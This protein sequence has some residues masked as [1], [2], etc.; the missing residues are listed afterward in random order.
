MKCPNCSF[1][2]SDD[3]IS[4]RVC[5]YELISKPQTPKKRVVDDSEDEAL[6]SALKVLFGVEG[7]GKIMDEEDALDAAMM[8]RLLKKKRQYS[9]QELADIE[10]PESEVDDVELDKAIVNKTR[11]VR[12]FTLVLVIL[13]IVSLLFKTS[14]SSAPWKYSANNATTTPQTTEAIA[15][16]TETSTYE[17]FSLGGEESLE[18]VNAFFIML[19]EFIN[20]GNLNILTLF[21]NS[22]E[23]LDLLTQFASIG[24]L[25]KVADA[26]IEQSE[27]DES[28]AS[29]TVSTLLNRLINGQQTQTPVTW[30]FR[31]VNSS[32]RWTIESFSI[33]TDPQMTTESASQTQSTT[34]A[35]T[36]QR[37]T[38]STTEATTEAPKAELTGFVST[39]GFSGGTKS[40]GQDIASARYGHH[41]DFDRIVFDIYEWQGGQPQNTVD[42]ITTYS[43]SISADG[44]TISIVLN[45]AID[46]Y[47]RNLTLDLKGREHIKSVTYSTA[48]STE[49]VTINISLEQASL[50]KVFDVKSPAR[51]I[52]YF[53]PVN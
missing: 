10:S 53:A 25:E 33:D 11:N 51:L 18:P 38:Q 3:A 49:S 16:T 37:A 47:A 20:K 36:T 6:D 5:G 43:T 52:V 48:G 4:C 44:K 29:Y 22:Q 40:N 9:M 27:L 45:G 12:I 14:L 32:L 13:I 39:G 7:K 35:P 23:A 19:P 8:E 31:T 30:D 24:N 42:V 46:A 15:Q 50:Y 28:G 21:S 17:V 41:I 34:Q 1:Q 2:N 26:T